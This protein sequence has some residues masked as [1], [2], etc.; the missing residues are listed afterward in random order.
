MFLLQ[1]WKK[2]QNLDYSEDLLFSFKVN[3]NLTKNLLTRVGSQ[4]IPS[5]ES[6]SWRAR[7]KSW[8]K[9]NSIWKSW[10]P[11]WR[12]GRWIGWDFWMVKKSKSESWICSFFSF[13]GRNFGNPG[14]CDIVVTGLV[15]CFSVFL[16]CLFFIFLEFPSRT[17]AR[18]WWTAG[19]AEESTGDSK[20]AAADGDSK[21]TEPEIATWATIAM[22][23]M[24]LQ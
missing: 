7:S 4:K 22:M 1:F 11:A 10:K 13:F 16:F 17:L 24:R 6:R 9:R 8:R 2:V 18:S 15:F 19:K 14:Q 5:G 12:Q 21:V 23:K 3:W 20:T